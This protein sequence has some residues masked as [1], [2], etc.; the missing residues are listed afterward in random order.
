MTTGGAGAGAGAG[1]GVG[2]GVG[3][4]S[5]TPIFTSVS[6]QNHEPGGHLS[7]AEAAPALA[8]IARP[9][10]AAKAKTCPERAKRVEGR[11][12]RFIGLGSLVI[13]TP[14]A[15][16]IL[17]PRGERVQRGANVGRAEGTP[18]RSRG[19]TAQNPRRFRNVK[20]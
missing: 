9:V 16:A 5:G 8:R 12:A 19:S 20:N 15:G 18:V 10:A 11:N 2:A 3:C 17:M 1:A 13:L 4:A 6:A 14:G 7:S